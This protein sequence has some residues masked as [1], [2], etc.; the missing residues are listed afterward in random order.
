MQYMAQ[1]CYADPFQTPESLTLSR[2]M[3]SI[4]QWRMVGVSRFTPLSSTNLKQSDPAISSLNK[5][6]V[7]FSYTKRINHS[8]PVQL[9]L[10]R[11]CS[12]AD[13][14]IQP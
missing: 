9:T 4:K 14:E 6:K 8:K 12:R 13:K 2:L 3:V 7:A 11:L 1:G 5:H 10:N